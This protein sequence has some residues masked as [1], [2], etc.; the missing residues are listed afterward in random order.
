MHP[1]A[2]GRCRCVVRT[3]RKSGEVD[4][5]ELGGVP[6][7]GGV[8]LR[9]HSVDDVRGSLGDLCRDG[10]LAPKVGYGETLAG[11]QDDGVIC[12]P[13]WGWSAEGSDGPMLRVD[14]GGVGTGVRIER[15]DG[16]N[17][18]R[19]RRSRRA[20]QRDAGRAHA[21]AGLSRARPGFAKKRA[22][23]V[24]SSPVI[25]RSFSRRVVPVAVMST[26]RSASPTMGPSSILP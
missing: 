16:L 10:A 20:R 2:R 8:A 23:Q 26:M 12:G 14:G 5:I 4:T 7:Q 15:V 13:F 25:T 21:H 1:P 9:T 18:R 3:A 22:V 24:M 6:T 19:R 17:A 11:E